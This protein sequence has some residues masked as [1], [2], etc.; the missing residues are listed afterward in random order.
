[1]NIRERLEIRAL[2]N[3]II[4]V[5]ERLVSIVEKFLPKQPSNNPKPS[6]SPVRPHRPKPLKTVVDTI[7]NIVPLPW[8]K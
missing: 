6:P 5:V 7:N 2:I 3:L 8:R 1:M 4:S